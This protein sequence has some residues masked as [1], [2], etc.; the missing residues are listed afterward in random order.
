METDYCMVMTTFA[1]EAMGRRILERLMEERLAA[2]I[3]TI[4]ID[5]MYRWEGSVQNEAEILALI[6]TKSSH[7]SAIETL[8]RTYH[9]YECPEIIQIPITA[10]F[11][12]YLA[13]M[14][15]QC[16]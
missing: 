3:Q 12:P 1:D 10:G 16:L 5:S 15:A 13:W 14:D 8:I 9:E 4:V 6:K 7:Y 11:N 2:C